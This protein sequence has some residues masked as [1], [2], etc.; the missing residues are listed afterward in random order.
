MAR[1]TTGPVRPA[2]RGRVATILLVALIL[3]A[4]SSA[5]LPALKRTALSGVLGGGGGRSSRP[6]MSSPPSPSFLALSS[7]STT[8][9]GAGGGVE[10]K[11]EPEG[12]TELPLNKLCPEYRV[13]EMRELDPAE[14]EAK[15][16]ELAADGTPK[17]K[18][19]HEFW[20]TGVIDTY[21]VELN[22]KA[23]LKDMKAKANF[24][25]FRKGQVPPY[26]MPQV[27]LFSIQ[28]ALI[29]A[30][31]V[32]IEEFGL[33][34]GGEVTIHEDVEAI[35]KSYKAGVNITFTASVQAAYAAP[36]KPEESGEVDAVPS[37]S[38]VDAEAAVESSE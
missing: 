12:G 13:K 21:G 27:V 3:L 32:V 33:N 8:T 34:N 29:A 31:K 36:R 5:Y 10:L 37:P 22:K 11:P 4:T 17:V 7:A 1:S 19:T 23:L 18:P 2:T 20:M 24:P 15:Y 9:S 25:G 6:A 35:A 14:V 30:V 26:A 38:A 28:D 16:S